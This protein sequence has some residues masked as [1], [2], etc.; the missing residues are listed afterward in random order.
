MK[1]KQIFDAITNVPDELVEEAREISLKPIIKPWKKWTAL[2][3]CAIL[4]F[5]FVFTLPHGSSGPGGELLSVGF[6][7]AYSYNDWDA[8]QAV[9]KNNPVE[10]TFL[11][12]VN[13]FSYETGSKL[14]ASSSGNSN[15]SPLSLY[16]ALAITASGARGETADEMLSLLNMPD[17]AALSVQCGNL[18][19]QLYTDNEI[20]KLK[21]A[22]SVWMNQSVP[23]KQDFVKNA[24]E[25]F[26]ASSF[27]VDFS[28]PKTAQAMG[29]WVSEHTNGTLE[30]QFEISKDKILS[31]LNTVYFYDEWT[32][33]FD[34]AKTAADTFHSADG[35]TINTD[36]MN[37]T[38]SSG[39][40]YKGDGFI[41]S[42]L[43]LKNGG[44]MIFILPNKGISPRELLSTPEKM[45]SAFEGGEDQNGEV[46]W[47]MP[48]FDFGAKIEPI[49]A[50]KALG[51]HSAFEQSA[52]FS[53]ITDQMAS[54]SDIRQETHIAVDENGVEASAFTEVAVSTSAPI[55]LDKAEMILD[56]P[57]LYGI[58]APDGTLLFVGVCE[59]PSAK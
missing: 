17:Q 30:P 5:T 2:A 35:T 39:S 28:D 53:G 41:R 25:N 21:I 12:A 20:G 4:V 47:K 23:W 15:Y 38:N 56:R 16:Y 59:N 34:S 33:K 42:S 36:F 46:V 45:Q 7:K 18:Y 44:K 52:D 27:S 57:F 11:K 3:A 51:I 37:G 9:L 26:Y 10:D 29:K 50:L 8:K 32:N 40:F 43:S 48:K 49:D 22:N 54:V 14:L 6:P 55:A 24:A 58:A 19:R 13:G 1:E 31:I